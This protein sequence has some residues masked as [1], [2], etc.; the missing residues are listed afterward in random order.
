L[1]ANCMVKIAREKISGSLTIIIQKF[2]CLGY[3]LLWVQINFLWHQPNNS[4][5]KSLRMDMSNWRQK[6][7]KW[8]K[9]VHIFFKCTLCNYG[10][11]PHWPPCSFITNKVCCCK[12]N[13]N[14]DSKI[15]I[16]EIWTNDL[17]I[18]CSFSALC[19]ENINLLMLQIPKQQDTVCHLGKTSKS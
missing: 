8:D 11:L 9:F 6:Y 13:H 18:T 10:H 4:Q 17:H 7:I 12:A 5:S 2:L 16:R 14:T 19:E 3:Q 15:I 1:I